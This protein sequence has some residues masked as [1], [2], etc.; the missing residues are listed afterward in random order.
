MEDF[1]RKK[2]NEMIIDEEVDRIVLLGETSE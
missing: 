1:I 2:K